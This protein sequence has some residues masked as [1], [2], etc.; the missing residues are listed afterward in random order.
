MGAPGHHE[1]GGGAGA[2]TLPF[3]PEEAALKR[4]EVTLPSSSCRT[5]AG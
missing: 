4:A 5:S 3:D 1:P 2:T